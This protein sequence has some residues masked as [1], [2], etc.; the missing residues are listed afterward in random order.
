MYVFILTTVVVGFACAGVVMLLFRLWGRK[1]PK[2]V[3]PF[4]AAIG[5]FAYMIWD[6]YS[7]FDRY[8]SR[9]PGQISIVQ[10][11]ADENPFAPWTLISAPVNRFTAIDSEKIVVNPDNP[12]QK[13]V[14]TLLLKKGAETLA[15]TH[16]VECG[17]NRRGYITAQTE[18][19]ANGFPTGIDEWFA[20]NDDDPLRS[21]C[22]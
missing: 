5:M 17:A 16:L 4:V 20:M 12:D 7:W 3:I 8:S 2:Y 1:A 21:V 19:D 13:R 9:L 14:T 18:L 6:E 11:F 10:T 15:L 22:N